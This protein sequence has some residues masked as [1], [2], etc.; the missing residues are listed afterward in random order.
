MNILIIKKK[1]MKDK[2]AHPHNLPITL[3]KIV[4]HPYQRNERE[5]KT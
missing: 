2:L 1:S 3:F 5:K 4:I